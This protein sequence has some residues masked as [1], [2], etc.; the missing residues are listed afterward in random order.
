MV[1]GLFRAGLPAL[2]GAA[3]LAFGSGAPFAQ[4]ESWHFVLG[5]A[6][7]QAMLPLQVGQCLDNEQHN[8]ANGDAIQHTT[9]GLLV[10]RKSDNFTAFTDGAWTWVNGPKGMEYRPNSERFSWEANPDH[11]P[12]APDRYGGVLHPEPAPSP[13]LAATQPGDCPAGTVCSVSLGVALTVP[14]NWQPSRPG[15]EAPG[16]LAFY[17]AALPHTRLYLS[18]WGTTTDSNAVRAANAGMDRL[19]QGLTMVDRLTRIAV[20]VGG[21]EGVE[22]HNVPGGP[23]ESTANILAHEGVLYKI[24]LPGSTV[25]VDQQQAVNSLRFIPR[26]GPFPPAN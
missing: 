23:T 13:T 10:W 17:S 1:R 24:L 3:M 14:S 22:V 9:G 2:L 11:L 4:A 12:L 16:V 20:Q 25:T 7:M 15:Q 26:V 6:H 5:F 18:S 8:P 19:L 21:A